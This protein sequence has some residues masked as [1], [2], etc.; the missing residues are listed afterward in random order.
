MMT[1]K[2]GDKG[3]N[4]LAFPSPTKQ[5]LQI[6]PP[7]RNLTLIDEDTRSCKEPLPLN[8]TASNQTVRPKQRNTLKNILTTMTYHLHDLKSVGPPFHKPRK[9]SLPFC[10]AE[11]H[12]TSCSQLGRVDANR[13]AGNRRSRSTYFSPPVPHRPFT[14]TIC[15]MAF[16]CYLDLRYHLLT[17]HPGEFLNSLPTIAI[18]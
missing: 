6:L 15:G 16:E 9:Y 3:R 12:E 11:Y 18:E 14:C 4:Y 7:R 2:A 1:G 13:V 8:L 10:A 17:C 5:K